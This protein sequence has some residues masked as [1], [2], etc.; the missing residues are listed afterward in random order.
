VTS[1][2]RMLT[3]TELTPE[4]PPVTD[5]RPP[6]GWPSR[7][8]IVFDKMSLVY[9]DTTEPVLRG[10]RALAAARPPVARLTRPR[11]VAGGPSSVQTSP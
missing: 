11:S 5:V 3:Y 8:E 4:A 7:G 6:A 10:R 2:E 1:V 9:P